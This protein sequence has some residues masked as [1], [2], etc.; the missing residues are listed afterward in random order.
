MPQSGQVK[1]VPAVASTKTCTACSASRST[2]STAHGS[3]KPRIV[4][5]SVRS[6]T[7]RLPAVILSE[8]LPDPRYSL[9]SLI[10]L[11]LVSRVQSMEDLNST[12]CP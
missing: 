5:Y 7:P 2:R 4:W 6:S 10:T 9:K 8:K 11:P 12:A 1:D 3:D